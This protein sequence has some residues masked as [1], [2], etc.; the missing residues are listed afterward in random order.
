MRI[1][2]LN[3]P[4]LNLLG[5][6]DP[7][8]YGNG[9]L[10]ELIEGLRKEFPEQSIEAFQSNHEGD[11]IDALQRAER[12]FE[13]VLFNPGGYTHT[14]VAL[15]D[16]VEGIDVNVIEIHLSHIQAREPFR[17]HSYIAPHVRG[18]IMGFGPDGYRLGVEQL[19]RLKDS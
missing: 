14:S 9:S 13:G 3:G 18:S 4:N 10:D 6:R 17:S 19:L 1:L 12:D 8:H 16:A 2:V 15:G 7:S 11:L 5:Q